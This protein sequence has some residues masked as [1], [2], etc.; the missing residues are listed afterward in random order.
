MALT[1]NSI[2]R[3]NSGFQGDLERAET[4]YRRI[5]LD[6]ATK[7]IGSTYSVLR[8]PDRRDE[9]Q[10]IFSKP[11]RDSRHSATV[12]ETPM[13]S[14]CSQPR[15][16]GAFMHHG[17]LSQYIYSRIGVEMICNAT[18]PRVSQGPRRR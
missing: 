12:V 1:Q 6:G 16:A 2:D 5:E 17:H 14:L 13:K 15:I 18:N 9:M 8:R 3:L 11:L 4:L 10:F 7:K